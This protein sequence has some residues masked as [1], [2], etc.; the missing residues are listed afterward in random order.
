MSPRSETRNL[1]NA[2]A[3]VRQTGLVSS[4]PYRQVRNPAYDLF[5]RVM[6]WENQAAAPLLIFDGDVYFLEISLAIPRGGVGGASA[7]ARSIGGGQAP[8]S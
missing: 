8:V 1:T 2:E 4:G 3:L 6:Q 7:I 5:S